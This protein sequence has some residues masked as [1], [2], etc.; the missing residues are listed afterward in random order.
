MQYLKYQNSCVKVDV[1]TIKNYL[2][3]KKLSEKK[4]SANDLWLF[5]ENMVPE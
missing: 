4:L 3:K 5:L 1:H 2:Q